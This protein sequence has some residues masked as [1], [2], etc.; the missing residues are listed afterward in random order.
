MAAR[1]T[2]LPGF[3][4]TERDLRVMCDLVRFGP[5]RTEQLAERH[6]FHSENAARARL[7][8]LITRGL[9]KR[10]ALDTYLATSGG[11]RLTGL[12]LRAPGDPGARLPHDMAVADL[13]IWL[14]TEERGSSFVTERELRAGFGLP[15]SMRGHW[16]DGKLVLA[17]GKEHAIELE[18]HDKPAA[19]YDHILRWF[20]RALIFE[21]FRWYVQGDLIATALKNSAERHDMSEFMSVEQVPSSV[22][23]L[24]WTG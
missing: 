22:R 20:A 11:T 7:R 9:L 24:S 17:S 6:V 12:R 8:K 1:S 2:T 5:L 10:Y 23:V 16:P 15:A 3:Q 19:D 18:L 14:L 4:L 13:A 21:R